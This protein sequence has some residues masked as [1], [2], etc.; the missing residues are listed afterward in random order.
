MVSKTD[1]SNLNLGGHNLLEKVKINYR[2]LISHICAQ[3]E[4]HVRE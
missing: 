2:I 1:V 3:K 4:L